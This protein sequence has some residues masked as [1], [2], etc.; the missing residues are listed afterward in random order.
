MKPHPQLHAAA[1][2]I[3][4][5]LRETRRLEAHLRVHAP[6]SV[7]FHEVAL[8][9]VSLESCQRGIKRNFDA[10]QFSLTPEEVYA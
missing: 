6:G 4:E 3:D 7:T 5:A 9:R 2:A 1:D 8:M 10:I